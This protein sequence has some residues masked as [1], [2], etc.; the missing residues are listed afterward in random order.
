MR[1]T[2]EKHL[3][4]SILQATPS[5]L[6]L[7][8]TSSF[9]FKEESYILRVLPEVSIDSFKDILKMQIIL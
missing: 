6:I 1:K 3:S 5:Y 2:T 8:K 9:L 4:P 7:S